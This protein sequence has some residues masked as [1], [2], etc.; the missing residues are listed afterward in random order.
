MLR[1]NIV[2][3]KRRFGDKILYQTVMEDVEM[4]LTMNADIA[5]G[6]NSY[7]QKICVITE[8]WV[9][10]WGTLSRSGLDHFFGLFLEFLRMSHLYSYK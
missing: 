3:I 5:N 10:Q 1:K 2:K 9:L 7:L 6:Y 8:N 4:K